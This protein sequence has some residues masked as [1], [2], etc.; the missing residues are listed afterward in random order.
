MGEAPKSWHASYMAPAS[1]THTYSLAYI[2]SILS[3]IVILF[4][5]KISLDVL[6]ITTKRLIIKWMKLLKAV[7]HDAW[8]QCHRC[9]L[10][11]YSLVTQGLRPD[12]LIS[13]MI[14]ILFLMK[15]SHVCLPSQ[16]KR[17]AAHC[18]A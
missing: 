2:L 10:R 3:M 13:S 11:M 9:A 1:H 6:A 14:V 5:M 17:L 8:L 7:T 16:P 4:L 18:T 12:Y 15:I